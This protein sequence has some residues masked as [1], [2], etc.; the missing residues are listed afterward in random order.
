MFLFAAMFG[1]II[2]SQQIFV[3]IYGLGP[4]FPLAFAI[5]AAF[6]AVAQLRQFAHRQAASACAG[7]AIS[8]I[9]VYIGA[10]LAILLLLSLMG[11]VPFWVFYVL[12]MV[13]QFVFALGSSN[14]NSL[15][16]EPLGQVAG[17]AAAV[18][19]F[20]QTVGG[21]RDRHL[22]RPA[23]QRHADAQCQPPM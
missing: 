1:F 2:S 12:L 23:V 15:S 4:W 10:A 13:I 7:S 11:P 5:V 21:A 19:G 17:T 20:M 6:M 18:F 3:G 16:M 9:L 8:P 22:H 14:M